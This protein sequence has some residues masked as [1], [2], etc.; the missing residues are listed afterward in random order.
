[1]TTIE[2]NTKLFYKEFNGNCNEEILLQLAKKGIFLYEPLLK[3]D[4]IKNKD[5]VIDISIFARQYFM[6]NTESQYQRFFKILEKF[7]EYNLFSLYE[8]K[9][10]CGSLIVVNKFLINRLFHETN[11]KHIILILNSY[12]SNLILK[13][14]YKYKIISPDL[15][16]LFNQRKFFSNNIKY[17]LF[18]YFYH[19]NNNYLFNDRIPSFKSEELFSFIKTVIAYAYDIRILDYCSKVLEKNN[20]KLPSYYAHNEKFILNFPL[21]ELQLYSKKIYV[22]NRIAFKHQN[23]YFETLINTVV[24]DKILCCIENSPDTLYNFKIL[25]HLKRYE[26]DI[27][28][29]KQKK[30]KIENKQKV[31][32]FSF[33]DTNDKFKIVQT[34]LMGS[35]LVLVHF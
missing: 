29:L 10:D 18:D 7:E 24:T 5:C 16:Y 22:P 25:S 6:I 9:Y 11:E 15:F 20:G 32:S 19:K 12:R 26:I 33:Q 31:K 34:F 3:F 14:L 1:M 4:K 17:E 2:Q 30:C 13:Y 35:L 28:T 23:K 21:K 8:C 27:P